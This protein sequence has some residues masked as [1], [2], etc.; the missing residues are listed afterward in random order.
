MFLKLKGSKLKSKTTKNK[1]YG[2][3][4]N[5]IRSYHTKG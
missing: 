3:Q 5:H 1:N 2:A 4:L